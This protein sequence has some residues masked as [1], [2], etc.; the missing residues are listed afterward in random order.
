LIREGHFWYDFREL[1]GNVR[2]LLAAAVFAAFFVLFVSFSFVYLFILFFVA[3][4]A[5]RAIIGRRCPQCDAALKEVTSQR[6]QENAFVLY[7]IWRCPHDGYEEQEKVKGDSG[8]FGA[9]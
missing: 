1:L 5:T 6:D 2:V 7:I 4:L 3:M 8:L 9:G